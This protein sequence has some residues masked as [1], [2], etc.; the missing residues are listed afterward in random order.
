MTALAITL[1]AI[2]ALLAASVQADAQ[3]SHSW[4][5]TGHRHSA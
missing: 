4:A 5:S 3:T 2:A 1:S